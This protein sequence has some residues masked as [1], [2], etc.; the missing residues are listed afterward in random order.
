MPL[1]LQESENH[2]D[3]NILTTVT[4]IPQCQQYCEHQCQMYHHYVVVQ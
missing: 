4:V 1:Q 2:E 3:K